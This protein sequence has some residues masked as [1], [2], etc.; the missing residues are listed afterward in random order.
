MRMLGGREMRRFLLS[1]TAMVA[2][3]LLAVIFFSTLDSIRRINDD[4][5]REK[6]RV[7]GQ[8]VDYFNSTLDAMA[9]TGGDPAYAKQLFREDL[10]AEGGLTGSKALLDFLSTLQRQQFNADYLAYVSNGIVVSKSV[11]EGLLISDLEIPRS[12]PDKQYELLKESGGREGHFISVFARFPM[13]GSG[14]EFITFMVDRTE[15][16]RELEGLYR[17]DKEGLIKRQIVAGIIILII[18]AIISAV[19]VY[20]LTRRDITGPIE[21]INR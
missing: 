14:E 1:V 7:I 4:M 13:T 16:I 5:Q 17:K 11:R 12:M 21:K 9:K 2:A 6:E 19:G 18:G 20:W 15:N 3:L 10:F 8:L